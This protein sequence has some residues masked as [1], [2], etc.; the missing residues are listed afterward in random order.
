VLTHDYPR[1]EGSTAELAMLASAVWTVR[2]GQVAAAEFFSNRA[3]ALEA[4]GLR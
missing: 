2:D 4:A 3:E 1:R